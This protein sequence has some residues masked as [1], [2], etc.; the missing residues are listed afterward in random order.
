MSI[1]LLLGLIFGYYICLHGIYL[2][3]ILI[4]ATQLRHYQLGITFGEFKRIADSPL[5]LPFTVIIPAYNEEKVIINAVLGALNLRY[6]QHEVIVVN[7]GSQDETLSRMIKRFGLRRV[8]KVGQTRFKTRT[9]RGVYESLDFPKL[10][11]IDKANGRRADAINAAV[12]FSR[13]PVLC[14][15]DADCVFEE[16]ALL[17]VV[18]PFLRSN[19]VVAAG[20]I[21]RPANGL[22]VSEG[23][24]IGHGMPRRFLPLLQTVEYLRSFQWSRLG[25][26]TLNSMLC[27][28]GAFLVIK[29]DIF[30][31]MGGVD[32]T[33]ITDDIDVT[34]RLHQYI[35]DR[36]DGRRLK[37]AYIPDPVCYT[38]VPE[39]FRVFASQRNRWQR[40]T[41]QTLLRHWTMTFN[42]R[43]GITG[44]FGMPFFLLF[45][46]FAAIVEGLSYVLIPVVYVLG[47]ATLQEFLLFFILAIVLGTFLS[48]TAVLLQEGTRLRPEHTPDL[49]RLLLAGLIENFGYHQI[50]LVWRIVGT[51]DYLVRRRHDL[52]LMERYGSYQK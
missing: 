47:Y 34:V 51:F 48:V 38:E 20:G 16:D 36:Q 31:D 14:I 9:I 45:E 5:T 23:R 39:T 2:L 41:L 27:I 37:I 19:R 13:Y 11:V 17:R 7:D 26:A 21:V 1:T 42:P 33:A 15:M 3:L 10:V 12:N 43:Y 40:G 29:K 18:R 8:H 24:I 49:L 52:G 6:P 44:L 25:L 22:E 50:H 30:I 46:A 28:S 35:Y 32:P 4:G